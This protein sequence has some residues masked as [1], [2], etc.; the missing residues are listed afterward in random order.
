MLFLAEKR[1]SLDDKF[2]F[3]KLSLFWNWQRNLREAS[4][5]WLV[6]ELLKV[7]SIE[8][9]SKKKYL[10]EFFSNKKMGTKNSRQQP[11]QPPA[12]QEDRTRVKLTNQNNLKVQEIPT[13]PFQQISNRN[14]LRDSEERIEFRIIIFL[15]TKQRY[16]K[17]IMEQWSGQS[18]KSGKLWNI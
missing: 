9:E 1:M 13:L 8:L 15:F 18:K 16:G 12:F 5:I 17:Y 2:V 11:Q 10:I 14:T 3:E 7:K 6:S 4:N